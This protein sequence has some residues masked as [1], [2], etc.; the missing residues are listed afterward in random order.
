MSSLG[1]EM[2]GQPASP[3]VE[4]QVLVGIYVSASY[5]AS[6]HTTGT[7]AGIAAVLEALSDAAQ[8]KAA[9]QLDRYDHRSL[10][11]FAAS[12]HYA[13]KGSS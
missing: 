10:Y 2:K 9:H 8:R 7:H 13:A 1:D 5:K 4:L 11:E 3:P 6:G 12:M